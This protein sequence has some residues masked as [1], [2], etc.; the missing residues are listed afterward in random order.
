MKISKQGTIGLVI[1]IQDKIYPAMDAKEAFLKKSLMLIQGLQILNIPIIT[2]QQYTKGLGETL[3]EIKN[4]IPEFSPLD[5]RDFSCCGD[6]SVAEIFLSAGKKNIIICGVESHVC[7]QQT[8]LDL[9]AADL[10][11]IIIVDAVASR[12]ESDKQLAMERFR[13]EGVMM[14]SAESILFELTGSSLAPE[15]K[16]ISKLVR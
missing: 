7:V 5:K 11:P 13:Y 10:N 1:D 6:A 2:T 16:D 14:A 4:A 15:F 12:Y 9:K 3:A 8:A